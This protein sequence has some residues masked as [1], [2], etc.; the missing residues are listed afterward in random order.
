MGAFEV[1]GVPTEILPRE[2]RPARGERRQSRRG[3]LAGAVQENANAVRIPE[4][5]PGRI[6]PL[7]NEFGA[8]PTPRNTHRPVPAQVQHLRAHRTP[9]FHPDH[10]AGYLQRAGI[11]TKEEATPGRTTELGRAFSPS[12]R[13]LT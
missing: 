12:S 2:K 6:D 9:L 13:S 7:C 8:A 10:A 5:V 3:G 11:E 1:A 4:Q